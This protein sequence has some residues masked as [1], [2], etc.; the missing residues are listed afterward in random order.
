MEY[1]E[2][3]EIKNLEKALEFTKSLSEILKKKNLI[4]RKKINL[5]VLNGIKQKKKLRKVLRKLYQI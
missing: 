2:I 5:L 3:L 1:I 4:K